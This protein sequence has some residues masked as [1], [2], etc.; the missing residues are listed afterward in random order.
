[1]PELWRIFRMP[2][3]L[4]LLTIVGLVA[5]LVGDGLADGLSW[6]ALGSVVAV[7]YHHA[8]P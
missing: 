4:A 3:V 8:T 6:L 5:A 2:L 1:M 7:A